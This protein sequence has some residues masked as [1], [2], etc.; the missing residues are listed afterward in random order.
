VIPIFNS[1][2]VT[3]KNASTIYTFSH[4][5]YMLID[6]AQAVVMSMNFNVDAMNNERNYGFVDKD[7]EDIADIQAVFDQDW[8]MANGQTPAPPNLSCTRMIISPVNSTQRVLAFING[9]KTTLEVEALYITDATVR[10]AI[11]GAKN[12]GVAVRVI[13]ES[14][15][16]QNSNADTATYFKNVGV[17]VKFVT[18]QFYLH[19]KLIVADG[20]ALVG[21]QNY[22]PTS[23]SKNR[24]VAGLLFE[25]AAS[26]PMKT[27]F[28][29]DWAVTVPAS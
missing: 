15:S 4:A 28:E 21:S 5:K 12:R 20:V 24:E 11:G 6:H 19:A 26:A 27:Q 9:S 17:P 29:A 7:A 25:P 8:A 22:S 18:N 14:P 3:W 13:L 10:N 1:G 2:G 23:L 16:D